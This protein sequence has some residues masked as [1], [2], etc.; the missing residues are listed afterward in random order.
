M[1]MVT[2]LSAYRS[3]Q[4]RDS[5]ERHLHMRLWKLTSTA[6]YHHSKLLLTTFSALLG[7]QLA[8]HFCTMLCE[9]SMIT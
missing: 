9:H 7:G 4:R 1:D 8:K 3:Q 5:V 6:H 2:S